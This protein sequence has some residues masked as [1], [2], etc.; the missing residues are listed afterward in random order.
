MQDASI[1]ARVDPRYS[2][3]GW[4][5]SNHIRYTVAIGI[6]SGLEATPQLV[7]RLAIGGPEQLV[8]AN[9]VNVNPAARVCR[10]GCH[11]VMHTVSVHIADVARDPAELIVGRFPTPLAKYGHRFDERLRKLLRGR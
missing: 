6:A 1:A 7:A 8:L 3:P 10:C 4:A 11:D 5:R 9:R 2:S